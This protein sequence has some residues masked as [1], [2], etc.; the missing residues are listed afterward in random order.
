MRKFFNVV[1]KFWISVFD[2]GAYSFQGKTQRKLHWE[3]IYSIHREEREGKKFL[4][5]KKKE[6]KGDS[7]LVYK[8]QNTNNYKNVI[9]FRMNHISHYSKSKDI[10]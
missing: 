5:V 8:K 9:Q 10:W 4:K 6:P 2:K 3:G 1:E 7:E